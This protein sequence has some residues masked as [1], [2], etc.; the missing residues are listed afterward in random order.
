[1]RALTK[2][3]LFFSI[4]LLFATLFTN[5]TVAQ[6]LEISVNANSGLFNY[7]GSGV[8]NAH[9][10][11]V[12]TDNYMPLEAYSK[13]LTFSYGANLQGQYVFKSSFIIGLQAGYD[14]IRNKL[15]LGGAYPYNINF[16]YTSVSID[17][18]GEPVTKGGIVTTINLL[19]L[20]PTLAIAL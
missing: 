9:P 15:N 11:Y 13:R 18:V 4:T 7:T 10:Y 12:Y 8:I 20:T 6:K 2:P 14:L 3:S 17:Y 19:T 16:D 1:M 5:I